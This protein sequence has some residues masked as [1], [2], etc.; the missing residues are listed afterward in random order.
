[1]GVATP[2]LFAK[3]VAAGKPFPYSNHDP[4]FFVDLAAIPIGARVDT[5]VALSVLAKRK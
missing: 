4:G 3:A 2:E 5:V 1:V